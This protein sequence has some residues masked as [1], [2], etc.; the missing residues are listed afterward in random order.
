MMESERRDITSVG[1]GRAYGHACV[2][3]SGYYC[4]GLEL[5]MVE[6]RTV[7]PRE[8]VGMNVGR[9]VFP[10]RESVKLWPWYRMGSRR[11]WKC[12]GNMEGHG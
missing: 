12:R 8:V 5:R 9:M 2:E 6:L 10:P 11:N 4:G 1:R 7:V 3:Q